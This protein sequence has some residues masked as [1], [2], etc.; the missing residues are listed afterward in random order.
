M[1]TKTLTDNPDIDHIRRLLAKPRTAG[2]DQSMRAA[3][4]EALVG[5]GAGSTHRFAAFTTAYLTLAAF[6]PRQQEGGQ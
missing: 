2:W 3:C 5:A 4:I 1:T 6:N